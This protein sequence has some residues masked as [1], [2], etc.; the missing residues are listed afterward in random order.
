[1]KTIFASLVILMGTAVFAQKKNV[2]N[3][4]MDFSAFEK[5]LE[6]KNMSGAKKAILSAKINIDLA[7]ENP[8]TIQDLK[9]YFYKGK[10][11]MGLVALS[12]MMVED[13][14]MQQFSN[15]ETMRTG[16]G[17]WKTCYDLDEKSR[18]RDEI[19]QTIMFQS[20]MSLSMAADFYSKQDFESAYSLYAATLEMYQ[21]IDLSSKESFGLVSHNAGLCAERLGKYD[22]AFM[23]YEKAANSGYESALCSARA[24]DALLKQGKED[25]AMQY[26]IAASLKFPGDASIIISMADIA[27]RTG[28][29]EIA[30]QSLNQAIAK[31]PKNGVY[32]WAIGTVYLRVNKVEESITSFKKAIELNPTDDRAYYSLGSYY[33]N[34]AVDLFEQASR[35]KLGDPKFDELDKQAKIEFAEAAIYLE[36]VV[37]IKGD[38]G[39]KEILNNLFT[40]YRKL[41]QSE[42]AMGFKKRADAIK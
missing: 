21:V 2:Q 11:Y 41:D 9:M 8:E 36:K 37:E 29:D 18:Y 34:K 4:V 15:E 24:A 19:A 33:Y 10:V 40:I 30:I 13:T 16:I 12:T 35:V 6:I 28:Q 39:N 26:I 23:H 5:A 38:I 3:A 31:D 14:D 22:L 32:Y 1:M 17:A 42:K 20:Q 27:L 25:E 7:A